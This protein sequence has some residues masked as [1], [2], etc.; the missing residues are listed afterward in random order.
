LN[1]YPIGEISQQLDTKKAINVQLFILLSAAILYFSKPVLMPLAIAG[2]FALVFMPLCG[3]LERKGCHTVGAALICG[4]LFA[5]LVA[6]V[7][8]FIVW[9]VQ[10]IAADFSDLKQHFADYLHG[11][12]KYLHD[13][14]GMDTLKKDSPLPIPVQPTSDGIGKIAASVMGVVISFAINILLILVYM[15]MLLCLR[16]EIRL[17]IV[18]TSGLDSIGKTEIVLTQSVKVV[19][20]YLWGLSIVIVCL[21][22]MY[23][24]GFSL[25]GVHT[26]IFFA[27]LCGILEI[28]PFVGNITGSTLTS[29]MALSQGGGFQMVL[30]VLI[31]YMLI[32]AIQFYIISPLVMRTQ[33]SIHPLFTI[34]VLFA[35]DLLWGISGMILA[36]P[37]L[38]IVKIICDHIDYL[39]PLGRLLGENRAVRKPWSFFRRQPQPNP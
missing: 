22:I 11:F 20:Q 27:I 15:I 17:F 10:H 21:W 39:Q 7:V 14:F 33:V 2:M 19:Q 12:R 16:H 32:Q 36:I 34:V 23:S 35:G 6:A 13:H 24:I 38:G 28:I 30:G 5:T 37:A 9:H 29:L 31:T 26:P 25:V 18:R 1:L 8:L 4:I 3:W